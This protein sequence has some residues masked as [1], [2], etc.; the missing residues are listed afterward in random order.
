MKTFAGRDKDW[1]DITSVPE[2]QV[3]RL[4]LDLM[5]RELRPLLAAKEAPS[6]RRSWSAGSS[7]TSA[8]RDSFHPPSSAVLPHATRP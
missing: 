4:D 6:L 8:A 1:A 5:R 2:R 7:G 3:A